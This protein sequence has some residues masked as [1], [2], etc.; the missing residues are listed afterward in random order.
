[1]YEKVIA[2]NGEVEKMCVEL[3]KLQSK[4]KTHDL[5]VY[6]QC[7]NTSAPMSLLLSLNSQ[8]ANFSVV[9]SEKG[10]DSWI[11]RRDGLVAWCGNHLDVNLMS[12]I[13]QLA[14]IRGEGSVAVASPGQIF[15][16]NLAEDETILLNP[17]S[18]VA[19]T[20]RFE[21]INQ[22]ADEFTSGV[23]N[24]V[25]FSVPKVGILSS[26][27][28]YYEWSKK[29]AGAI[30]RKVN[31]KVQAL[32]SHS[33]RDLKSTNV[34]KRVDA[35]SELPEADLG[36]TPEANSKPVS[37]S[38]S[39]LLLNPIQKQKF[40]VVWHRISGAVE[41]GARVVA[42][43]IYLLFGN[44]FSGSKE[45]YMVEFK[46]P[47]TLLVHNAVNLKTEPLSNEEVSKLRL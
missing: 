9:K 15:K 14:Q 29:S 44:I 24:M 33:S 11:V 34:S 7:F 21:S 2:M 46:G 30:F 19:Y 38:T 1:M 5:L 36:V 26:L 13:S 41:N 31:E 12:S 23:K 27:D 4:D 16:I 43:K 18:I 39:F 20:S 40:A 8:N 47:K 35:T 17:R 6:Q 3:A 25:D 37:E 22:S 32:I 45:R 28:Y 42:S 10:N